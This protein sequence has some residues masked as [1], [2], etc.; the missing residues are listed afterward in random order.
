MARFEHTVT[1]AALDRH[2]FEEAAGHVMDLFDASREEGGEILLPDG[3]PVYGLRLLKGRHLQ[4]GAQYGEDPAQKDGEG[5]PEVA[6]LREWRPSR[7][8]EVES[9]VAEEGMSMRVGVRLR[10]PRTPKA[11]EVSL[12]GH[13]PEGGSLYRFSG[14]AKADLHAWWAAL[15]QPS[16]APPAARAPVIGK[17]VHRLGKARLTVT[18]RPA[19]DSTWRVTVVLSV[20]GRWLLRPVAAVGLFF[21]RKPIARGFREGVDDAA[22]EWAE[23]LAE[24]PSLHGEALRAEIADALTEPPEPVDPPD[25]AESPG[26]PP[27]VL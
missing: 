19:E 10:E 2:W 22:E 21:A 1:V 8:V 20:R 23:L 15:E 17:A 14:R 26:P 7:T 27:K 5:A 3:R 13:N 25:P 6:V 16:S 24:L 4:S 9:R 18:P 11:L 12:D